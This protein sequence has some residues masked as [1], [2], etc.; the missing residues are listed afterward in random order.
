[1]QGTSTVDGDSYQWTGEIQ[2]GM[3]IGQYRSASGNNGEF[4]LQ[5]PREQNISR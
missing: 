5:A 3:L 4:R 2:G 1:L